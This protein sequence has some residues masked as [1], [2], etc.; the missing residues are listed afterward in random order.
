MEESDCTITAE[1]TI[2]ETGGIKYNYYIIIIVCFLKNEREIFNRKQ[3]RT[4]FTL[5]NQFS[6]GVIVIDDTQFHINK[7]YLAINSAYFNIMFFGEFLESKMNSVTLK[8]VD[9]EEFIEFLHVIYPS[10]FP[11]TG[12]VC[13]EMFVCAYT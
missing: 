11:V 12:T 9:K 4:D 8:N 13:I 1:I 7:T 10:R 6:D 2:K 3:D 5:P